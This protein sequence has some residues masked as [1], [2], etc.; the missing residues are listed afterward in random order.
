MI[1]RSLYAR[2]LLDL[3]SQSSDNLSGQPLKLVLSYGQTAT[4]DD[5]YRQIASI[6]NAI[7]S[8]L[9]EIVSYGTS[10]SDVVVRGALGVT[11]SLV[12]TTDTQSLDNKTLNSPTIVGYKELVNALGTVSGATEINISSGSMIS[13]TI[14]G[15]TSFTF[16][17]SLES[18]KSYSL[19]MVITNGG[20]Y[21]ITWPASIKWPQ[22]TEPTL[23][24]SGTDVLTFFSIDAGTTWYSV[25]AI[26]DCK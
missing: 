4:I 19:T 3:S 26:V 22:G 23:T 1:I 15:N 13:V 24:V 25:A 7:S 5:R 12:G 21:T 2:G 18:G 8:G 9:V 14:G 6:D 20:A 10:D 16:S 17:D 11:G